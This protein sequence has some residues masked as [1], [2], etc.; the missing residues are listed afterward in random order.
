MHLLNN[1]HRVAVELLPD[2]KP[3]AQ[4]EEEEKQKLKSFRKTLSD[5]EIQETIRK[6]FELKKRQVRPWLENVFEGKKP[7]RLQT[8]MP[9]IVLY[10]RHG[11]TPDW[12]FS[13]P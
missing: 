7:S 9:C 8:I 2:N 13:G 11:R 12:N 3:G 6:T 4:Q 5:E 1:N 10:S